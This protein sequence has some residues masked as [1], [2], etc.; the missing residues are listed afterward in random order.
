[1]GE[2]VLTCVTKEALPLIRDRTRLLREPCTCGRTTGRIDLENSGAN[3]SRRAIWAWAMFPRA[4]GLKAEE[5]AVEGGLIV[6][7]LP[8]CCCRSEGAVA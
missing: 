6:V 1:M 2:L 5:E 4:A 8:A 7:A 3:G